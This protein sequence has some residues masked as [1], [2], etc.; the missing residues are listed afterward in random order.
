MKQLFAG[1]YIHKK[2]GKN[3]LYLICKQKSKN[4]EVI[5]FFVCGFFFHKFGEK[6]LVIRIKILG[7]CVY[8]V[9]PPPLRIPSSLYDT[10]SQMVALFW[11][12]KKK[13]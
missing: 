4:I 3:M 10:C 12:I 7:C 2:S 13:L 11:R 9:N 1:E 6:V 5:G 8:F